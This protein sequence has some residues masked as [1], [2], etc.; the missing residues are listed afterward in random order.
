MKNKKF[1]YTKRLKTHS[2]LYGCNKNIITVY[3]VKKNTLIHVG[4]CIQN[5]AS[6]C[7]D[8]GEVWQVLQ[9]NGKAPKTISV[10]ENMH[11]YL[12]KNNISIKEIY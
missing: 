1:Y 10:F 11:A 2:K 5:T 9:V 4:E 6:T 3:E 7:G 12:N 8:I